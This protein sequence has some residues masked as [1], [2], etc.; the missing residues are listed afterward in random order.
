MLPNTSN[1]RRLQQERG[2]HKTEFLK[3]FED[4]WIV[5]GDCLT[6]H[7]VLLYCF[8]THILRCFP[9]PRKKCACGRKQVHKT[10]LLEM[11]K[12]CW[13]CFVFFLKNDPCV[14]TF[15]SLFSMDFKVFPKTSRKMRLRQERGAHK[16]EFLEMFEDFWV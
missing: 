6:K 8:L 16:T 13:V 1:K 7:I 2:A 10:K 4:L 15:L 11:F 14:L 3:L 5:F 9:K 12:D